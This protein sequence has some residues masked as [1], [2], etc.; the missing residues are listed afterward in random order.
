[1]LKCYIAIVFQY[2]IE[3]HTP[4]VCVCVCVCVCVWHASVCVCVCVCVC[5]RVR[6]R[7]R[8]QA[9]STRGFN[10][11]V[12]QSGDRRGVRV[13]CAAVRCV[14]LTPPE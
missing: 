11:I 10:M 2:D 14:C 5:V 1:M 4:A 7:V 3:T 13:M 9:V 8:V 12:D 6:V